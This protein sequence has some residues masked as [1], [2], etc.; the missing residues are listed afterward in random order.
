MMVLYGTYL[1]DLASC[2]TASA[3]PTISPMSNVQHPTAHRCPFVHLQS[4]SSRPAWRP[5]LG[6][7]DPQPQWG[8]WSMGTVILV[9]GWPTPI[10][11]GQIKHIWNHQPVLNHKIFQLEFTFRSFGGYY[12]IL[13]SF[14][15]ISLPGTG[16]T[17]QA[18]RFFGL[19]CCKSWNSLRVIASSPGPVPWGAQFETPHADPR[20]P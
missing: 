4:Q 18:L 14:Q 3:T 6:A 10:Y 19:I 1:P 2:Q 7:M 9:G 16:T 13:L 17:H 20:N 12:M 15:L 5:F 8:R 11:Y